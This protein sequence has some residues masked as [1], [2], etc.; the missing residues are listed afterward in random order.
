MEITTIFNIG[1][2]AWTLHDLKV[3]EFKISSISIS[4]TRIFYCGTRHNGD[5]ITAPEDQCF[6]TKDELLKYITDDGN[7]NL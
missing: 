2:H 4:T 5:I 1:A 7:E 6:N 3:V